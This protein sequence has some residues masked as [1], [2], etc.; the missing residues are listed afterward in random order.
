MIGR[1][2]LLFWICLFPLV[3][4]YISLRRPEVISHALIPNLMYTLIRS[5][6]FS[7]FCSPP[8]LPP[9]SPPAIVRHH[10][11]DGAH[12]QERGHDRGAGGA[13]HHPA[14]AVPQALLSRHGAILHDHSR[15]VDHARLV[16]AGRQ[17]DMQAGRQILLV[18]LLV[19][20]K[21]QLWFWSVRSK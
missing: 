16:M 17:A 21:S 7:I 19:V 10:K 13:H 12:G 4:E 1:T 2:E 14:L 9:P 20:K 15:Q 3:C 11:E 5:L 18:N 6:I 8:H